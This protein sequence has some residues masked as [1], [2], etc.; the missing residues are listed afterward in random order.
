MGSFKVHA[1]SAMS[2]LTPLTRYRAREKLRPR[3]D[4]R[5]NFGAQRLCLIRPTQGT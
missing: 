1:G 4:H 3:R 5:S 2:S